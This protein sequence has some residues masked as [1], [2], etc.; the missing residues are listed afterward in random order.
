MS[1]VSLEKQLIL[2]TEARGQVRQGRR[3]EG[4]QEQQE[5]AEEA[6]APWQFPGQAQPPGLALGDERG[7]LGGD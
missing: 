5:G 1:Q 3:A 6:S 2:A 4:G 7:G